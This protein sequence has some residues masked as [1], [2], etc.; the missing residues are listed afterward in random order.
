MLELNA[1]L[2]N[3]S[4]IPPFKHETIGVGALNFCPL[5]SFVLSRPVPVDS[6]KRLYS[7]LLPNGGGGWSNSGIV[8]TYY[9][10]ADFTGTSFSRTDV[11]IDFPDTTVMPGG[12][13]STDPVY[14]AVG[15]TSFSVSWVGTLLPK[16]N[17]SYTLKVRGT[18]L[19]LKINGTT[20]A[21]STGSWVSVSYSF[22]PGINYTVNVTNVTGADSWSA[23]VH[24]SSASASAFLEEAI[25]PAAPVGVNLDDDRS[26]TAN[27]TIVGEYYATINGGAGP[28][29]DSSGWPTGDFALDRFDN[30]NYGTSAYAFP[31]ASSYDTCLGVSTVSFNGGAE[32]YTNGNGQ[33]LIG[34]D[35]GLGRTLTTLN[36]KTYYSYG[37]DLPLSSLVYDSA[38][39][40]GYNLGTNTTYAL[41]LLTST[42]TNQYPNVGFRNTDRNGNGTPAKGGTP[43]NNGLTNVTIMKPTGLGSTTSY[44]PGT[45]IASP[46]LAT[47]GTYT[48]MRDLASYSDIDFVASVTS[49]YTDWNNRGTPI[50]N[51]QAS[52]HNQYP[53]TVGALPWEIR[54]MAAN[55]AGKDLYIN[56]PQTAS[57]NASDSNYQSSYIYQLANLIKNGSTFNGVNYPGLLPHLCVY[58]EYGNENWNFSAQAPPNG[59]WGNMVLAVDVNRQAN[60]KDWQQYSGMGGNVTTDSNGTVTHAGSADWGALKVKDASDLFRIVFGDAVMPG[61]PDG[62]HNDPRIR[63]ILEWQYGGNNDDQSNGDT[64]L[65]KVKSYFGVT[66]NHVYWGGGGGWYSA[67]NPA[68]STADQVF[69]NITLATATRIDSIKSDVDKLAYF[70]LHHVGYEGGFDFEYGNG[71]GTDGQ[72]QASNNL[73]VIPYV[74]QTLN[75]YFQAGGSMPLAFVATGT[76]YG[77]SLTWAVSDGIWDTPP[78]HSAP[79]KLQAYINSTEALPYPPIAQT[80]WPVIPN[81]YFPNNFGYGNGPGQNLNFVVPGSGFYS[82]GFVVGAAN[83]YASGTIDMFIDTVKIGSLT[84]LD[85]HGGQ[86]L[87]VPVWLS[88]GVHNISLFYSNENPSNTQIALDHWGV[89]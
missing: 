26:S 25:G 88:D 58:I 7:P 36:G 44:A 46:Y 66:I 87:W 47:V 54:I 45:V 28:A 19:V 31:M 81:A 60:T 2:L 9:K 3:H 84:T 56:L 68:G 11:R 12:S 30:V 29:I 43:A 67:N 69:S 49:P 16:Y 82:A 86:S 64:A 13:L 35:D 62:Y 48:V 78:Y 24:W 18:N 70:G 1:S 61:G 50:F 32:L 8:G 41:F 77:Y 65:N 15:P 17:Q 27:G 5:N 76:S 23:Q 71:Q 34:H 10:N 53:N 75:Q 40:T 59:G 21:S 74:Q 73:Q 4:V 38:T 20:V 14:G 83:T 79:P 33:F 51:W 80:N 57:G 55:Q 22:S 89:Q 37:S 85:S 6:I 42:G 72:L 63:P 39:A 52:N